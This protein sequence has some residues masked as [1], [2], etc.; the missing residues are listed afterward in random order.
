MFENR[1]NYELKLNNNKEEENSARG[2]NGEDDGRDLF[3][4][5]FGGS[6]RGP[7]VM[8]RS[9]AL[10]AKRVSRKYDKVKLL[11]QAKYLE[12]RLAMFELTTTESMKQV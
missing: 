12:E 8:R 9:C 5:L 3:V 2:E 6:V 4:G 1:R 7:C 10:L 11:V